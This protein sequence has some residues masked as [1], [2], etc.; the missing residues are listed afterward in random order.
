MDWVE[1]VV[2]FPTVLSFVAATIAYAVAPSLDENKFFMVTVMLVVYWGATFVNFFGMKASGLISSI[3][4]I[5]GTII[6]GCLLI[7]M[8]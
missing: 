7:I 2:W 4:T 3:G 5:A 6:P 1:N 8:A